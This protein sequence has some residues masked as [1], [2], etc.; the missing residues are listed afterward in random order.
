MRAAVTHAPALDGAPRRRAR[1]AGRRARARSSSGPR[2]SGSAGRTSISSPASCTRR[3]GA[4]LP[5]VQGH[6]V[7][8]TI[9]AV[10]PGCDDALRPGVRVALWPLTPCGDCY[11]CRIGRGNVCDRFR[12][13]GIHADGGLQERLTMPAAQV[14]PSPR[15][16]PR[17]PP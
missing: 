2:P 15:T 1:A 16:A 9:D 10:G 6:E 5:R 7:A 11:P 8:A 3:V 12:L 17:S 13:I 14:F 4:T